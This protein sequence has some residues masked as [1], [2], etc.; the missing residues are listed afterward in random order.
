MQVNCATA[1]ETITA[2]FDGARL[3]D[4]RLTTRLTQIA[5]AISVDP[6]AGFPLLMG[7]DADLEGFYRFVNNQRIDA[8]QILAPHVS[9]TLDRCAS[10][11]EV[12]V[13]HD[14]TFSVCGDA[15]VVASPGETQCR[16]VAL[17]VGELRRA[18]QGA[19]IEIDVRDGVVTIGGGEL[20]LG[21]FWS[22]TTSRPCAI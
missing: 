14:T 6:S 16:L 7:S 18:E 13:V 9:A 15:T 10:A 19:T 4:A 11:R 2:E 3:G 17:L 8:E 21:D 22:W 1:A 12:L 5:Q 20:R